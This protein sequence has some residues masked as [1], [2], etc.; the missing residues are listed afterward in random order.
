MLHYSIL[1]LSNLF[2]LI[3]VP[4]LITPSKSKNPVYVISSPKTKLN[5][6]SRFWNLKTKNM[7]RKMLV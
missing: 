4:L 2:Y 3:T 1:N 7:M 5:Y 6:T